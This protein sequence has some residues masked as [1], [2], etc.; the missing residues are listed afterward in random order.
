MPNSAQ[1]LILDKVQGIRF[2]ILTYTNLITKCCDESGDKV[3]KID[4]KYRVD[5]LC[6][7]LA[8]NQQKIV[9]NHY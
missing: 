3:S 6:W 1:R 9:T 2:G 7:L 5:F 4:K 8:G